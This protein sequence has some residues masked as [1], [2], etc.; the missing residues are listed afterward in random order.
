VSVLLYGDNKEIL[1]AIEAIASEKNI[2]K[3]IFFDALESAFLQVAQDTFGYGYNFAVRIGRT[4]GLV[5]FLRELAVVEEVKDELTEIS[6][7]D[8][9]KTNKDAKIGDT[10]TE[11]MPTIELNHDILHKVQREIYDVVLNAEKE[12]EYQ[13]FNNLFGK[14]VIG[15][16]KRVSPNGVLVKIDRFECFIPRKHLIF[17]ELDRLQNSQKITGI[18]ADVERS[19]FRS[20]ATLSRTSPEFLQKL[21]ESEIS[22][23]YDGVIQIKAIAR[24]AGSRSKVAVTSND[25][26]VD[27]VATCIGV[28]GKKIQNITKELGEEKIDIIA[29]NEDVATFL[30]NSL[31]NIPV[32][33]IVADHKT[34]TLDVVLTEENISNAIGRRGQNVRL[35][36]TLTGWTVHFMTEGENSKRR[37]KEFEEY[38]EELVTKLDVDEIVAQLLVAAGF[39]TVQGIASTDIHLLQSIEGFN[40]EIA[41]AIHTRAVEIHNEELN[42]VHS[43]ADELIK[44]IASKIDVST[45]EDVL[46]YVFINNFTPQEIADFSTDEL[47]DEIDPNINIEDTKL[48]DAIMACRKYCGII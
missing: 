26:S 44:Q 4:S 25:S 7:T 48:A 22:E 41:E 47:K 3:E 9:Q 36:S 42:K 18:V 38:V 5:D 12:A 10:I 2:K 6:L 14:I 39:S 23:I 32:V 29:W 31:K 35:L 37:V 27:A 16:V 43:H 15:T 1:H 13:Y 34:K 45:C 40:K 33:N 46:K 11:D 19:N 21:F 30:M 17:G 20:Q 28:R 24:E 8:A